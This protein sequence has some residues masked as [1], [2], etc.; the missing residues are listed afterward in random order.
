MGQRLTLM[1]VTLVPPSF[2]EDIWRIVRSPEIRSWWSE[3]DEPGWPRHEEMNHCY[4]LVVGDDPHPRGFITWYSVDNE[5]YEFAGIDLFLG[6]SAHG[7]GFGREA[8]YVMAEFL[9]RQGHHRL[10]IDPAASN[11]RAIRCYEAIGFKRIGIARK[12]E[13]AAD[14]SGWRD[15]LLLDCL[16]EDLVRPW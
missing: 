12:Y 15:G 4:Y 6:A 5:H 3:P 7:Q 16:P 13:W 2:D 9:F 11:Q 14:N 8:V 1:P 10:V